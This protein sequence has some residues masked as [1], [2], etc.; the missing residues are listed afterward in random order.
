[1]NPGGS[2]KY[3][4]G[5][6]PRVAQHRNLLV[7]LYDIPAERPPG[8]R[9][10][11]PPDALGDAV[12]SP[13]PSEEPL[14]A[15]TLAVFRRETFDE[16]I[17][18]NGWTFGRKGQAYVALWSRVPTTWS[19]GDV[20]G[21]DGLIAAGLQHVWICQLGREKVDGPFRSWARRVSS[22]PLQVTAGA[23]SYVAPGVG[24]VAFGWEGPFRVD[25][26]EVPLGNFDRFDNPYTRV[27]YGRTRYDLTHAGHRLLIDFARDIHRETSPKGSETAPHLPRAPGSVARR[28]GTHALAR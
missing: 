4:Q 27:P 15:H 19:T 18:Q 6:L 25:G 12:P 22:A 28:G 5:R 20:F 2:R 8:P 14:A 3:W 13:A 24:H 9:T 17:Q 11:F 26:Q 23:V 10:V 16:V 21:G 7:A 1:M